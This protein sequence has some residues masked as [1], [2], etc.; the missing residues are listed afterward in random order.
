M[1]YP[2]PVLPVFFDSQP[3]CLSQLILF[4]VRPLFPED[5]AV[6]PSQPSPGGIKEGMVMGQP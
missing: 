5:L 6:L 4:S 2:Q 1:G 3:I